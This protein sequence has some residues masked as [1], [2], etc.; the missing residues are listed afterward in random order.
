MPSRTRSNADL[1]PF[2]A[3]TDWAGV[4]HLPVRGTPRIACVVPSLTELLFALGLG[5][6]VVARTGFCIHPRESVRAVPKIGGTKD[7]DLDLLARARPTHLVVNVDE[8]RR[9]Q[10][11]AAREFVPHVIVTH[12]GAPED[13]ARLYALFGAIFDRERDAAALTVELA[14]ALVDLDTAVTGLPRESVLY[15]IW[16]KPWMTVSR[17]T[18]IAAT[19]ARAGWDTLPAVAAVRYPQLADDDPAWR[20]AGRVLLSSEPYAFRERDVRERA[21]HCGRPVHLVDGEMTSW[22]GPRAI[23]GLRHLARLRREMAAVPPAAGVCRE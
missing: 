11:D 16:K 22:Y 4:E 14:A 12:P 9:E 21:L 8:N 5:P 15:V 20:A 2:A 19:L 17:A 23:A 3:R 18:Y 1:T 10:V 7:F 13:N 6:H